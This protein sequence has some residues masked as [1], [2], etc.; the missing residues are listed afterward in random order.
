MTGYATMAQFV[1]RLCEVWPDL[2]SGSQFKRKKDLKIFLIDVHK[3]MVE[4]CRCLSF[5]ARSN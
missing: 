5:F 2:S 3:L 1:P 4:V